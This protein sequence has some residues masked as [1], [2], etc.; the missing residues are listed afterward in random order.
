MAKDDIKNDKTFI[1]VLIVILPIAA[2]FLTYFKVIV[3]F[4]VRKH[5]EEFI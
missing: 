3:Y 5:P 2:F 4:Y 1:I